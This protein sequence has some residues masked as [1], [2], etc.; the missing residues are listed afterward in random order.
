MRKKFVYFIVVP[1]LVLGLVFYLFL[2]T[3][4]ES[5]LEYA[6][7]SLVGARVEID[8]LRLTLS[9]LGGEFARLQVTNPRDTWKNTFETGR[10]RFALDF[11]QLLR[12]KYIVETMEINSLVLGTKR[13]TDGALP[14][15]SEP[16]PESSTQA[17]SEPTLSQQAE[18]LVQEKKKSAPVFDLDQLRKQLNVDS[19]LNVQNL[20]SV[21]HID[22]LK[23]QI[24]S[25]SQQWQTT[26]AEI[27]KSKQTASEIEGKIRAVNVNEL[28][29]V[30]SVA[31]AL[32]NVNDIQSGMKEIHETFTNRKSSLT[33]EVNRLSAS[34]RVIDDLARQ[35]FQNVLQLARLPDVG[36]QGLAE[37]LLGKDVL[38][39][40]NEYLYWI[41]FAQNKIR[42]SSSKPDNAN[43][44]RGRGQ[45]IFFPVEKS[46]PKFWIKKILLSGGTDEEQDPNYF[47]ATGEIRNISS[48]QHI[49]GVPLTAV[50]SAV[51]GRGTIA[52]LSVTIDRTKDS[53]FD[54]YQASLAGVPIKEMSLG[55]SDFVPAKLSNAKAAFSV[56]ANVP[57][58]QFDAN[59][60]ISLSNLTVS[61]DRPARNTVERLVRDVLE[62]VRSFNIMLRFWKKEGKLDVA[63]ETDLDNQ[64]AD[65]TKKVVG[66][67]VNRLRG[68]LRQKLDRKIAEKRQEVERLFNQ[69]KDEVTARLFLYGSMVKEKVAL[70]EAK[71][72]ELEDRAEGEK[73]KQE[74]VLKKKAGDALKGILKKKN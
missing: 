30:E 27:E 55:R 8:N 72:K 3:W 7:E 11:D 25:A 37:L 2:D 26:L 71:K 63:F 70:V 33:G 32:K 23:I 5:A 56:L 57:K 43:P 1:L 19:L 4:I 47:Y 35:D 31:A 40:A 28:K 48:N 64:L 44:P 61:F 52:S 45:T 66:D 6:G 17:S 16:Q 59:A 22:S 13:L 24:A 51:Q 50:L 69:K 38:S 12:G 21:R 41:D 62:S 34:V 65:R 9:P 10:A 20:L 18:S 42:N 39:N 74:D 14:K 58:N 29:S 49:T 46:Y 54:T 67:E 68:E 36:M 60:K 53:P 15:K 73:R